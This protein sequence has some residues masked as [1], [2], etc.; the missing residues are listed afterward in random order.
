MKLALWLC[1][2]LVTN[3][4]QPIPIPAVPGKAVASGTATDAHSRGHRTHSTSRRVSLVLQRTLSWRKGESKKNSEKSKYLRILMKMNP[5]LHSVPAVPGKAVAYGTAIG[6]RSHGQ[7]THATSRRRQRRPPSDFASD[8][9]HF[10]GSS[11]ARESGC[12]FGERHR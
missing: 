5:S 4:T 8:F 3:K 10:D 11:T 12:C 9:A 6:A 1:H 2:I 7:R